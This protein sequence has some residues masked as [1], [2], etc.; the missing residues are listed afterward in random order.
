MQK[1]VK[2]AFLSCA[3]GIVGV[4][5]FVQ[6]VSADWMRPIEVCIRYSGYTN[7]DGVVQL[8]DTTGKSR[9]VRIGQGQF[10]T[11]PH[12]RKY[13]TGCSFFQGWGACLGIIEFKSR[14]DERNWVENAMP[15][16]CSHGE[17]FPVVGYK[18]YAESCS[19]RHWGCEQDPLP[20]NVH[21]PNCSCGSASWHWPNDGCAYLN[22]YTITCSCSPPP[23]PPPKNCGDWNCNQGGCVAGLTC[24]NNQCC[25]DCGG[26][27]YAC[28]S[29]NNC[30]CPVQP[31]TVTSIVHVSPDCGNWSGIRNTGTIGADTFR[32]TY[33]SPQS[34]GSY[35]FDKVG[36]SV[37]NISSICDASTPYL[38][39]CVQSGYPGFVLW[40]EYS[41]RNANIMTTDWK[42]NFTYANYQGTNLPLR[43]YVH[44]TNGDTSSGW[45]QIGTW[46]VDLTAPTGSI[47][48]GTSSVYFL[49]EDGGIVRSGLSRGIIRVQQDK[50]CCIYTSGPAAGKA[51]SADWMCDR[52]ISSCRWS[53]CSPAIEETVTSF[54]QERT[55]DQLGLVAG[56][57]YI[58]SLYVYDNACNTGTSSK[59]FLF[60]PF[61]PWLMTEN[62]DTF[63]QGGHCDMKIGDT[64]GY[65]AGVYPPQN[66]FSRYIISAG[67]STLTSPVSDASRENY[68]LTSYTDQN[69]YK[70][71]NTVY[72]DLRQ[73]VQ[74]NT[75]INTASSWSNVG[76]GVYEYAG[77]ASNLNIVGGACARRAVIFVE[78]NLTITPPFLISP[79]G[80]SNGCLF[81]VG[82][83]VTINGGAVGVNNVDYIEAFFVS[84]GNFR[85]VS[86]GN[87]TIRI[88]GGV[89]AR[90]V[91]F[92]RSGADNN[93]GE[94][95]DYD[96]RYLDILRPYLGED[97]PFRVREWKYSATN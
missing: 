21:I 95:I 73:L 94:I 3:I 67:N 79:A 93:P 63:A 49:G 35:S 60:Q 82:G 87:D 20:I 22:S 10:T 7:Y 81:V 36:F 80:S 91:T 59:N 15:W 56:T 71:A 46:N 23:P 61:T 9:W 55:F 65:L 29:A 41:Q 44:S 52:G 34:A 19:D 43:G 78:G 69:S 24:Y 53:L 40:G 84:G 88:K 45:V 25:K 12:V 39:Y 48:I 77:A 64:S 54:P 74:K 28:N 68:K 11:S 6:K 70:V 72:N 51:C 17:T 66:Y 37:G 85:T 31:P 96:P 76:D 8:R 16:L 90:T 83:N 97:Y 57:N 33:Q 27:V 4:L 58:I 2:I 75:T 14:S 62:G 13:K 38:S 26:G 18:N 5:F 89:I 30:T 92:E 86:D 32:V 50:K 1:F 47:D 42:I